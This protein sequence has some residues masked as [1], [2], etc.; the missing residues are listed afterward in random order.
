LCGV[1]V[2]SGLLL[3]A[4]ASMGCDF[5]IPPFL[6]GGPGCTEV[7]VRVVAADEME[8]SKIACVRIVVAG[9]KTE[10]RTMA[11]P[12]NGWPKQV[13]DRVCVDDGTYD[14]TITAY[15]DGGAL[16]AFGAGKIVDRSDMD[17]EVRST[18]PWS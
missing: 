6:V 9:S 11:K 4:L 3:E 16:Y 5:K 12:A 13:Q 18:V 14:V 15:D 17:I 7:W 10:E 1:I 8:L 2:A